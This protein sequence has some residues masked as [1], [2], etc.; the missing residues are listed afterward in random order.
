LSI[1]QDTLERPT[2]VHRRGP[3]PRTRRRHVEERAVRRR[4]IR[5]LILLIAALSLLVLGAT[6][7]N[8]PGKLIS[9]GG[10]EKPKQQPPPQET[11]LMIGT[12]ENDQSQEASW[13]SVFSWDRKAKRGFVMYIP[14]TTLV[15]IP[16]YGGGPEAAAKAL[17][18]GREP[19][20]ASAISN[21]LG[22]QFD[23]TVRISDQAIHA[24]FDK[25]GGVDIEV[26]SKLTRVDPD[27]RLRSVFAEG[28]QHLD[29]S[30]VSEYLSYTDASGDEIAR[31]ARHAEV[32][33]A[34][35]AK[36]RG[37]GQ[38]QAFQK[39]LV[40]SK[41]LFVTDA[42]SSHIGS[43]L[44]SFPSV[45]EEQVIFETMPVQAQG[46]D[47]GSQFYKPQINSIQQI[48]GRYLAASRPKGAGQP[49]RRVEILNGN[50]RPGIG[51]EVAKRLIPKGYRVVLDANA[52]SFDYKTT[53]I[54]IYSESKS[55]QAIARDIREALG[56]GDV[57]LSRQRQTVVDVTV[58]VGK[59]YR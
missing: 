4:R 28:Q 25:V 21:L 7:V 8:L 37:R 11:Q 31:G 45:K 38:V 36:Y 27:G 20:Q 29:G 23:G 49:G 35:F 26:T 53:Q 54:V 32:W 50:G 51:Q 3:G 52:K 16:G 2:E 10:S 57:V 59:D 19:L 40:D 22:I 24:L 55:A 9:P 43:F 39:L 6:F 42:N 18:L 47:T 33:R 46:V 12:I 5:N 1:D 13:L 58:V 41:D 56:V 44:A 34:L 15:E 17:A 48:V 14:R 30:R